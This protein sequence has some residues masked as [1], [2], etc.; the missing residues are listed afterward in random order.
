VEN[1]TE[2]HFCSFCGLP[3][4]EQERRLMGGLGAFICQFCAEH[5]NQVLNDEATWA[6]NQRAAP[7][8]DMSDEQL[9]Q[10]LPQITATGAQQDD[11]LH[12]WVEMLR[13][14]AVSWHQIGLALGVTRQAAWQRFTRVRKAPATAAVQA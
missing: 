6:A 4:N 7:W 13:E 10:M 9:L 12:D 3:G 11:F 2:H 5:A 8:H 14:R 1:L